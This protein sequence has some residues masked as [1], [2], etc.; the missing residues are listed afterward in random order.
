MSCVQPRHS[1]YFIWYIYIAMSGND[2]YSNTVV[3]YCKNKCIECINYSLYSL[4][5]KWS[6][7]PCNR[8]VA[9]TTQCTHIVQSGTPTSIHNTHYMIRIP[10]S[11]A[12][13]SSP[14]LSFHGNSVFGAHLRILYSIFCRHHAS[15]F[16][17]YR[18]H[19]QCLGQGFRIE[20]ANHAN[21]PVPA[22]YTCAQIRTT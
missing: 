18:E 15:T 20:I 21:S 12:P 3:W 1:F 16:M 14:S 7:R 2:F 11:P 4:F 22:I 17:W 19:T 13:S 9:R 10:Q 6:R 5:C 8:L